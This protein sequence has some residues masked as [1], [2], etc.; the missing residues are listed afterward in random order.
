M[1]LNSREGAQLQPMAEHES[2]AIGFRCGG[3]KAAILH[4]IPSLALSE[5]EGEARN[6]ILGEEYQLGQ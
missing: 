3:S 6:L 1:E 4:V 5:V 2:S